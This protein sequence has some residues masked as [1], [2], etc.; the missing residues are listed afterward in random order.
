MPEAWTYDKFLKTHLYGT[1]KDGCGVFEDK[2]KW[3]GNACFGNSIIAISLYDTKEEAQKVVLAE[4]DH[5]R[6]VLA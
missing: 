1:V 2:G 5:L 4:L 6:K 3:T